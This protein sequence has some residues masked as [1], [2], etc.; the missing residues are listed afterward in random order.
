MLKVFVIGSTGF[1][2]SAVTRELLTQGYQVFAIQNN[3]P[4]KPETGLE[5]IEGGIRGLTAN[6]IDRVGAAAIF[7]CA[8]PVM[9]RLRSWGRIIAAWQASRLNRFLAEQIAASQARPTL[10]FAS[11]SLV[12][13]SSPQPHSEA[14]PLNP[15]S[16]AREYHR[17]ENPIL[18]AIRRK[19]TKVVMLRFPWI[20]GNGSWFS[21]FYRKPLA[22]KNQVPLFG[23]GDN[24]MSLISLEDAARLMVRSFCHNLDSHVYN[25]FSPRVLSQKAFAGLVATEGKGT[26]SD[27]LEIFPR[28]VEKAVTEAFTSNILLTTDCPEWLAGYDFQDLERVINEMLRG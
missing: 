23:R 26:V 24:L 3:R 11:G 18:Q 8:R 13:G 27:Y 25:V 19:N 9:P 15:V 12:Y 17:G 20:L 28:G 2:G 7:H 21:W 1:L 22:E 16:Y 5:I 10:V 6:T 4:V 14:A